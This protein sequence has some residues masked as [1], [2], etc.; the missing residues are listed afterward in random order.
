MHPDLCVRLGTKEVIGKDPAMGEM[1]VGPS[2]VREPADADAAHDHDLLVD[3]RGYMVAKRLMDL[4]L[5]LLAMPIFLP[6]MAV[7]W[8]LVR[9]DSPG[10]AIFVQER[11]GLRGRRIRLYKFRTMHQH[12]DRSAHEAFQRSFVSG[13]L[14]D[15]ERDGRDHKPFDRARVTTVGHILRTTSLDELPQ[16]F[17]VMRGDMSLVGPR[18]NLTWEVEEYQPWHL[19][20]LEVLPGIT[21]LAQVNGRSSLS[22][23]KIVEYDIQYIEQRGIRLDLKILWWT[24][25]VVISRDGAR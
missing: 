18:P 8:L 6:L 9:L 22:F 21:G 3:Q 20:R 4:G 10:P 25:P 14:A 15:S 1:R 23:D 24:L 16:L 7:I 13:R 5:C 11:V 19:R 17:N 12:F 2:P